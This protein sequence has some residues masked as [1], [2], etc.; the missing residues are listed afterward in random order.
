MDER[1][2]A[3]NRELLRE[4]PEDTVLLMLYGPLVQS[5]LA[6]NHG[7]AAHAAELLRS[8]DSYTGSDTFVFYTRANAY[9]RTGKAQE[10]LKDYE[11]V[12]KLSNHAGLGPWMQL[13]PLA[14][15]GQA[16]AYTQIGDKNQSRQA[17]Q[18]FLAIWKDAD[19]D[20]PILKQA[21]AEYEKLQ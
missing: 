4:R 1:A 3:M 8:A 9:L 14:R 7:N 15:L 21:K 2:A 11:R 18:D 6:L 16:R 12:R 19:S 17:Y 10:A 20:I 13:A 5:L